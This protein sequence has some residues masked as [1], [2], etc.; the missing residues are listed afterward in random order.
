MC[1]ANFQRQKVPADD[2]FEPKHARPL[3]YELDPHCV[4]NHKN[5]VGAMH[6]SEYGQYRLVS[7]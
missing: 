1:L 5:V 3:G 6:Y 2:M 7:H 4:D